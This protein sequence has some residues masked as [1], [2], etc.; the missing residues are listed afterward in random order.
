[1]LEPMNRVA[2]R[3]DEDDMGGRTCLD[4]RG[5]PEMETNRWKGT[6]PKGSG[7]GAQEQE[8]SQIQVGAIIREDSRRDHTMAKARTKKHA[9]KKR[10]GQAP[11]PT[12]SEEVIQKNNE[13]YKKM[14]TNWMT[15]LSK[16]RKISVH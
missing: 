4:G 5:T 1:M 10:R 12:L 14:Y 16:H 6:E 9:A 3:C 11:P 15:P 13:A 7:L 8:H 2:G